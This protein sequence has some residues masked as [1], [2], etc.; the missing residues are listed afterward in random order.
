ME[1]FRAV[2]NFNLRITPGGTVIGKITKDTLVQVPEQNGEWSHIAQGWASSNY[3]EK[4]V[5]SG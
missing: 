3:L 4:I 1:T 5:R 2:D